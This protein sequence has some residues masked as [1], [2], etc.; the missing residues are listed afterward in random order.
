MKRKKTTLRPS[1]TARFA[2]GEGMACGWWSGTQLPLC[3]GD[4]LTAFDRG[5]RFACGRLSGYS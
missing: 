4:A 3:S 2:R 5:L 1:P